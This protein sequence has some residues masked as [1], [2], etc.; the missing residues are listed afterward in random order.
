MRRAQAVLPV[1][2]LT[3]VA[4][5]VASAEQSSFP[6]WVPLADVVA[7]AELAR[8][9]TQPCTD[10]AE[11]VVSAVEADPVCDVDPLLADAQ[12]AAITLAGVMSET[13]PA[14]D[15][16]ALNALVAAAGGASSQLRRLRANQSA[17]SHRPVAKAR[18]V[19]AQP[20]LRSAPGW[21]DKPRPAA[22][23]A[24]TGPRVSRPVRVACLMPRAA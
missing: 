12:A 8:G 13:L 7:P 22:V 4:L 10:T 21:R 15:A 5:V 14:R 9:A 19:V 3:P 6:V 23:R 11:L 1:G 24:A 2:L 18:V 17:A 16:E 20:H